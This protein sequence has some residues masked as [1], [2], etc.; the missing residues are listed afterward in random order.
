MVAAYVVAAAIVVAYALS[1]AVRIREER[2]R[3]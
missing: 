1:L 2:R 3:M